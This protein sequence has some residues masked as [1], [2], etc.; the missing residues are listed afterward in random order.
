MKAVEQKAIED[1]AKKKEKHSWLSN[2]FV[3]GIV[4][5]AILTKKYD[6]PYN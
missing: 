1:T 6:I 3:V 2:P 5:S 4:C